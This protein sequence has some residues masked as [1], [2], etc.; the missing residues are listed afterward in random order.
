MLLESPPHFFAT[1]LL[2]CLVS[3]VI[4]MYFSSPAVWQN[5]FP[6]G[7]YLL[8]KK[9]GEYGEY[10]YFPWKWSHFCEVSKSV[11]QQSLCYAL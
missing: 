10:D 1:F 3:F 11:S 5:L 7:G 4:G 8:Y 2:G 9:V 6:K